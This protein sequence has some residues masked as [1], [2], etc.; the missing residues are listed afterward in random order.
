MWHW[1]SSVATPELHS[2]GFLS[3]QAE[4]VLLCSVLEKPTY[5]I[6]RCSQLAPLGFVS[7]VRKN[8]YFFIFF[9]II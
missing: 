3:V 8:F 7:E 9:P 2:N 4:I 1:W 5:F 6:A